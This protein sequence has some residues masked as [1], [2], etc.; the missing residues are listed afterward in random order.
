MKD[1]VASLPLTLSTLDKSFS[2][3]H[4][5][6]FLFSYFSQETRLDISCQLSP[7]ETIWMKYQILFSVQNKKNIINLLSAEFAPTVVKVM[8][9]GKT[10][11]DNSQILYNYFPGNGSSRLYTESK[12]PNQLA[13][14]HILSLEIMHHMT[15]FNPY[16]S[17]GTFSRWQTDIFL[18][19]PRK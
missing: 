4:F 13:H 15:H 5:E 1:N 6:I 12:R 11:A 18:I 19:F 2:R 16:H 8:V 10:V 7:L 17:Q 14:P 3:W 9:P